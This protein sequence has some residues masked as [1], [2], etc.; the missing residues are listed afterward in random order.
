M[1]R[2]RLA[3]I[4]AGLVAATALVTGVAA[5]AIS[6]T[7][8]VS[9]V[10]VAATSTEGTFVGTGAG[11]GGD[12]LLW[13][14]VVDH[15]PLS[16]NPATPAA[17]TGGSLAATSYGNGSLTTL[18]GV[19]TGGS[20]TY[21]AALSSSSPCGNQVYDV[22]GALA[23]ASGSSTGTGTFDVYLTHYRVFLFG[24]CITYAATV[25][26]APGLGVSL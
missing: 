26:G 7:Y 6:S 19:F 24:R 15:T 2:T 1:R 12:N 8:V 13:K 9:G 5:A 20:V 22:A 17:I 16:S 25:K 10:E 3:M 14:A 4:A 21:D 18:A 11:S 23:L